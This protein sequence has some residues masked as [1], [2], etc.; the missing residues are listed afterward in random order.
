M[1][2]RVDWHELI[3]SVV[4]LD[5]M[6]PHVVA[7]ESIPC[8]VVAVLTVWSW[9]LLRE[10]RIMTS[11]QYDAAEMWRLA[12]AGTVRVVDA[13]DAVEASLGR[14]IESLVVRFF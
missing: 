10:E 13:G 6:E 8:V 14:P 7:S 5:L 12:V 4:P 11:W 3:K 1:W 2:S 9:F